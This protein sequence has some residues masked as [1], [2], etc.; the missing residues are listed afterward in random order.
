M[1]NEENLKTI[2]AMME[3]GSFNDTIYAQLKKEIAEEKV[4]REQQK[5]KANE[6]NRLY[7]I[8]KQ[9]PENRYP[10][11]WNF[12]HV[13]PQELSDYCQS[14][15]IEELEAYAKE[16]QQ[17]KHRSEFKKESAD[18]ALTF[19]T[20]RINER[21]NAANPTLEKGRSIKTVIAEERIKLDADKTDLKAQTDKV[22]SLKKE[23]QKIVNPDSTQ[24]QKAYTT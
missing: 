15:P 22:E 16:L 7:Q 5:Q 3:E 6:E 18:N 23:L 10:K 1:T 8:E 11:V 12:K 2:K 14:Y 17:G 9:K 24:S 20:A 21:I 13:Y 19:L 4:Q